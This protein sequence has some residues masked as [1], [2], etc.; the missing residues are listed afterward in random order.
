M[1]LIGGERYYAGIRESTARL[2]GIVTDEEETRRIPTCPDWS[3]RQLATH[4]GRGQRWAAEIVTR[5][6]PEFIAYRDVP[7]GRIPDDPAQRP[8]WLNGGAS[9]LIDAVRAGGAEQV[10]TLTGMGPAGYWA[11]RMAHETAVH[12]A[13]AE[14]AVGRDVRIAADLAADGIDE[15]LGFTAGA[16]DD[17]PLPLPAAGQT[18]HVHVTDDTLDGAGEWLVTRT[19]D[20]LAV[21][22]GHAKAD[23]AVRGP[24]APLLLVLMRRLPPTEP[25][26][27]VLGDQDLLS[28]WLEHTAF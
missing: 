4:V 9:L 28:Y 16:P 18:L 5:R 22:H 19:P 1:A 14:L 10:W 11:R 7:D 13:D 21:E 20:G 17:Q 27:E 23:V 26:V 25:G 12:L 15:W 3:L 6:S 24:A 2:A 8:D